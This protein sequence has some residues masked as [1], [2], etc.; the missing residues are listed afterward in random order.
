MVRAIEDIDL[1]LEQPCLGYDECL[2][3][4]RR[5]S[6]PFILDEIIDGPAML[7]RAHADRAMDVVNIKLSKVGGL[8]V[9]RQMRDFCVAMGIAMTI[10][11]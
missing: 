6:R 1:Y 8:T 3:I 4:R 9:A 7:L 2:S 10:E 5:T 11:D